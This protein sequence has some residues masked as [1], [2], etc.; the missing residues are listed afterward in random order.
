MRTSILGQARR[1]TAIR[2]TAEQQRVVDSNARI[3][4]VD[5]GAGTGKSSTLEAY[6]LARPAKRILL[7]CFNRSIAEAAKMRYPSNVECR[8]THSLAFAKVGRAYSH[9]L[10]NPSAYDISAQTKSG[11]RLS[12]HALDTI[13]NWLTSVDGQ[14]DDAHVSDDISDPMQRAA[15][16]ELA[17]VVWAGMADVNSPVKMPHDGYLK[18]WALTKPRLPYD[19]LLLEEAQ[20]TN[21]VTLDLILAQREHA[22]LVFVGDRH[23]GIYGF[24]K[25]VNAME[26][27]PADER[28][29]LTQ[30]FRYPEAIAEI[31]TALLQTYKQEKNV[32]H[33]LADAP[34]GW[35]VDR[36]KHYAILSRTNSTLFGEL[37]VLV[38]GPQPVNA[39]HYVGGF[40]NY[41]F[42]KVLDAY[43]LWA[44]DTDSI[45]DGSIQRFTSFN[46]LTEYS[47]EADDP[48]SKALVRVVKE[49][50]GD[51]PAIYAALKAAE[52]PEER[53][54]IT[55]STAH[56]A[57]GLEWQQTVLTEDFIELPPDEEKGYDPEEINLLYVA[58]TRTMR[59]VEIPQNL[60]EWF[61]EYQAERSLA[62]EH[63]G[64]NEDSAPRY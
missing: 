25:A 33:G 9:K 46:A 1:T 49:Y 52:V 63:S 22:Q 36:A 19:I 40:G 11:V 26:S 23:Q 37:A 45:R 54:Q 55:V 29:P 38:T 16:L 43:R 61:D 7:V 24:R 64:L 34:I 30:S 59:N 4:A 8:T 12:K 50:T 15:T 51:I 41:F 17:K 28:A 47:E 35:K 3:L 60:R 44:G 42:D 48:E 6:S 21:P 20:D 62:A 32:L 10:G 58:I 5:A 53:A 39:I 13:N 27:V 14:M 56:K 57:K 18:L 31:A 2:C